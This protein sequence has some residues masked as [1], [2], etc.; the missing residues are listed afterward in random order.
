MFTSGLFIMVVFGFSS[1][2]DNNEAGL[3][4][5]WREKKKRRLKRKHSVNILKEDI[6]GVIQCEINWSKCLRRM[7]SPQT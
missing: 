3:K 1:V 4:L 2:F 6:A 7:T 5:T